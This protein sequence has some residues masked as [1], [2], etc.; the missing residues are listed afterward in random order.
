M[1]AFN[2][3]ANW[4]LDDWEKFYANNPHD[5]GG[6]TY[7]GLAG[8]YHRTEVQQIKD[9]LR[10]GASEAQTKQYAISVYRAKFW[11]R[12]RCDL[13]PTPVNIYV[14]DMAIQHDVRLVSWPKN[15][16][17]IDLLQEAAE[18]KPDGLI[19]PNTRRAV[20]KWHPLELLDRCNAA[21]ARYYSILDNW[22][23]YTDEPD[24]FSSGWM[25]RIS[26]VHRVCIQY[27]LGSAVARLRL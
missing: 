10:D 1:S 16:G 13:W 2:F 15:R 27:Y 21:R 18:T 11:E 4:I 22:K 14:F 20:K 7:W 17:A 3:A 26:N 12:A 19:G 9:M 6:E 23:P 24:D 8:N 25:N 5:A